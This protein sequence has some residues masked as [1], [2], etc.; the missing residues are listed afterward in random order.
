MEKLKIQNKEFD[1]PPMPC[2][3]KRKD[4]VLDSPKEWKN[5]MAT[6]V[7]IS[8]STE[9]SQTRNISNFFSST[10]DTTDMKTPM[11]SVTKDNREQIM[12]PALM[13]TATDVGGVTAALA[14]NVTGWVAEGNQVER[15]SWG[16]GADIRNSD[17]HDVFLI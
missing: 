5:T 11:Y 6:I 3:C 16:E 14:A 1:D 4:G 2:R 10:H 17:C 7:A 8:N 12:W 15:A 13:M 9:S